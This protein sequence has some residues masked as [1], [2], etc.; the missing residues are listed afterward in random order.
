[1]NPINDIQ[2]QTDEKSRPPRKS[3]NSW[4]K[5]NIEKKMEVGNKS[6]SLIP[7][8]ENI[9]EKPRTPKKS[10]NSLV[11]PIVEEVMK[12]GNK[13]LSM[14]PDDNIMETNQVHPLL[15]T[16]IPTLSRT[17]LPSKLQIINF[18]RFKM[19]STTKKQYWRKEKFE[20]Y[21]E[22]AKDLISIWRDAYIVCSDEK[23]VI[24]K[25]QR[26]I[27]PML[28]AVQ[29]NTRKC[30]NEERKKDKLSELN[31]MFDIARCPCFR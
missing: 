9:D 18:I 11:E 23:C 22:V 10:R 7:N 3:R 20:L 1:M 31:K 2:S 28:V 5:P 25:I 27:I 29:K 13:S 16:T 17:S 21:R 6:I 8:E 4:M 14:I 19:N 30:T 24:N 15:G 26:N 12:I